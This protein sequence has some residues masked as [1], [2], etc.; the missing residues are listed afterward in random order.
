MKGGDA[1]EEALRLPHDVF[2]CCDSK[3][4]SMRP[5]GRAVQL[6]HLSLP[7]KTVARLP[8]PSTTQ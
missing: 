3:T 1:H 4:H 6:Q 2:P 7:R 5:F 8:Y